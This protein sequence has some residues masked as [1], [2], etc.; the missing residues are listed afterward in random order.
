MVTVIVYAFTVPL[1]LT[2]TASTSNEESP[3]NGVTD[4]VLY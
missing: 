4:E 3:E 1:P 2:Q